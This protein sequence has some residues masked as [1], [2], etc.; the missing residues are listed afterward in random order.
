MEYKLYMPHQS[1]HSKSHWWFCYSFFPQSWKCLVLYRGCSFSLRPRMMTLGAE[2]QPPHSWYNDKWERNLWWGCLLPQHDTKRKLTDTQGLAQ[3]MSLAKFCGMNKHIP[4]Q[5]LQHFGFVWVWHLITRIN[6]SGI[7]WHRKKVEFCFC[8]FFFNGMQS[9]PFLL[10]HNNAC[11]LETLS[12]VSFT[13][14]IPTNSSFYL[15]SLLA[16]VYQVILGQQCSKSGFT[17][18]THV[19]LFNPH[20]SV[21]RYGDTGRAHGAWV[22]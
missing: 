9:W 7:F 8:F 5:L 19:T 15:L 4:D 14:F 22:R 16:D 1:M 10:G 13:L 18:C 6:S 21:V 12:R 3:S 11:S 17:P 2:L 20:R